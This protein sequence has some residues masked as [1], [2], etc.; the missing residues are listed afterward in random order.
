MMSQHGDCEYITYCDDFTQPRDYKSLPTHGIRYRWTQNFVNRV[1]VLI[2]Q[3]NINSKRAV[4]LQKH[5]TTL[6]AKTSL[7]VIFMHR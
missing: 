1:F 7:N 5:I 4:E 2:F 3:R 6:S